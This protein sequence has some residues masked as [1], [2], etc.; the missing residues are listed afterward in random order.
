M[1]RLRVGATKVLS[2]ARRPKD[3]RP[4]Q[5]PTTLAP[6]NVSPG[7]SP[8]KREATSGPLLLNL[9]TVGFIVAWL[10]FA[11]YAIAYL[12]SN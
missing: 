4:K 7:L 3:S 10:A 12:I 6:T 2:A 8:T 9:V 1:P 11:C 5:P